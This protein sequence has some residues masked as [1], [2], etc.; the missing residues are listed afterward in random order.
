MA[1]ASGMRWVDESGGEHPRRAINKNANVRTISE[2]GA[3]VNAA[4]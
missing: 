1:A 3:M 4:A 2:P